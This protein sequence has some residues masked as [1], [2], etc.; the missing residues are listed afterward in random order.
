[1]G[2][3]PESHSSQYFLGEAR[4]HWNLPLLGADLLVFSYTWMWSTSGG[5]SKTSDAGCLAIVLS[6]QEGGS[7]TLC[8]LSLL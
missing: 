7:V 8:L 6:R 1:M 5:A 4:T 3:G 2:K